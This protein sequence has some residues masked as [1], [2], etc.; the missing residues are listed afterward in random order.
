MACLAYKKNPT[1]PKTKK[2][3]NLK[4]T[5]KIHVDRV[6][7]KYRKRKELFKVKDN[8]GKANTLVIKF[9]LQKSHTLTSH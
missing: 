7:L 2:S 6:F 9:R 8:I 1:K 3:N 4:L 5:K